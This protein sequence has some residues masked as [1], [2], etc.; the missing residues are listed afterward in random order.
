MSTTK[1]QRPSKEVRALFNTPKKQSKLEA[2]LAPYVQ[3][4]L[5]GKVLAIDPASGYNSM[6]GYALFDNGE[7]KDWGVIDIKY[8]KD[9]YRRLHQLLVALQSQFQCP[10]LLVVEGMMPAISGFMNKSATSLQRAVGVTIAAFPCPVVEVSPMYWHK[11]CPP[12]YVKSDDH[13][14]YMLGYSAIEAA[15]RLANRPEPKIPEWIADKLA[16]KGEYDD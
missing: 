1:K 5:S 15:S 2:S 6:P 9:V 3:Y 14:A 7:L 13:D 16:Q 11:R 12:N 4:A 10:D 8:D